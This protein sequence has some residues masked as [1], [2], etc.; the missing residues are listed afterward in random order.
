MTPTTHISMTAV[1]GRYR[2]GSVLRIL[3]AGE[4]PPEQARSLVAFVDEVRATTLVETG[5]AEWYTPA[6]PANERRHDDDSPTPSST[7][8][9]TA[10]TS[11]RRPRRK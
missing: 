6:P 5:L 3:H 10:A 2:P 11:P 7:S 9:K 1:W 4:A 8:P